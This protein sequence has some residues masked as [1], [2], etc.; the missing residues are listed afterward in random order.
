MRSLRVASFARQQPS[1]SYVTRV[2]VEVHVQLS[3]D[4]KLFSG[5]PSDGGWTNRCVDPFDAALPGTLPRLNEAALDKALNLAAI[6]GC[7]VNRTSYFERKHYV[8]PDLPH[9]YQI[10]QQQTPL[11]TSGLL[12][13]CEI[14][15]N[16]GK[17]A[18]AS[19]R[20]LEHTVAVERIQLEID[21]GKS[22]HQENSTCIDLNRAGCALVELVM[23]PSMHSGAQASSAVRELQQMLRRSG[24][25]DGNLEEG[26]LRADI[27]VSVEPPGFSGRLPRVEVKN[28]NSLAQIKAA[29]E[30]EADRQTKLLKSGQSVRQETRAF[31]PS[32]QTTIRLRTKGGGVDYRYCPEPDLEAVVVSEEKLEVAVDAAK[33]EGKEPLWMIRERW[34]RDYGFASA[35]S[36]KSEIIL[37]LPEESV[38]AVLFYDSAYSL[39]ELFDEMAQLPDSTMTQAEQKEHARRVM[40]WLEHSVIPSISRADKEVPDGGFE[41]RT[42]PRPFD[43]THEVFTTTLTT[44]ERECERAP[45]AMATLLESF[46]NGEVSSDGMRSVLSVFAEQLTFLSKQAPIR[47]Q[48]VQLPSTLQLIED[49]GL[50]KITDEQTIR[51]MVV[52]ALDDAAN[53]KQLQGLLKGKDKLRKYFFGKVMR[54]SDRRADTGVLEEVLIREVEGR[55][56]KG[57]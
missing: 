49:M 50:R 4:S 40:V 27:N 5:A 42:T 12:R 51:E 25:S 56:R 35:A 43:A 52:L 7:A 10:T 11:A 2:G 21:T 15:R 30:H 20:L 33:R 6:L 23:A 44:K 29:A 46:S 9:G 3:I 54:A 16:N 14:A 26:S 47:W 48:R 24:I 28:L 31:D 53:S 36:S 19:W 39:P 38:A 1:K 57:S 22:V 45:Q 37:M 8:Y 17:G 55:R 18:V 34:Q 13:Y 32:E 41:G